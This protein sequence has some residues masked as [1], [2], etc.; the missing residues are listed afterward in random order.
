MFKYISWIFAS[1]YALNAG[2]SLYRLGDI[3]SNSTYIKDLFPWDHIDI[4]ITLLSIVGAICLGIGYF[5]S[6]IKPIK[7]ELELLCG[8]STSSNLTLL[9]VTNIIGSVINSTFK[10]FNT[11]DLLS[12]IVNNILLNIFLT[13]VILIIDL[14]CTKSWLSYD[15]NREYK[16]SSHI[17]RS[18][19]PDS[20][21]ESDIAK[22]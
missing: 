2:L 16:T 8:D 19:F 1:I 18:E 13:S 17:L 7:L 10:S 5:V 4:V 21:S 9:K 11:S 15:Q 3:I 14:I 20:D 12:K 6:M 22:E